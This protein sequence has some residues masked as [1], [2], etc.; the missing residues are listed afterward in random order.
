MT[1]PAPDPARPLAGVRVVEISSFVAVPLAG[2]TL[3]Q[4]GAEVLR[5]DPV[6]GAADY[7]RW[8]LTEAGDSIYWAGLNKGKRSLAVDM[9]SD[10]GQELVARLIA[11]SGVFITN[12]AGRQWHS[13]DA[14]R[15]IR[16]DL[17]HVEVSGRHDG[18]TGVDYTVNAAIGFPLVTGPPELTTPVNHV[19]PAW[20]VTCG[21]YAALSVVTALR[22][23]DATGHGQ[24]ISIPLENVALAT[25]GNLSLLTEAMI[26][27]TSR[28][29]IGNAVY[30]TYGQNFTS[31]DGISYMV[32][33]LTGRHFRDLTALT[34]TTE[35]VAVLADSL[36]ADFSDEGERYRHREALSGLFAEWFTSHTGVEVAAALSAT[37]VLWE[38][39]QTFGETA[40]APRVTDNPLFTELDQPRVGRYLA[41]GLP[42][43]INGAYPAAVPAPALG[44][45]TAAV[46]GD[47]LAMDRG[48]I[49]DLFGAGTVA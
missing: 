27:G 20:D 31:S 7:K 15:Q 5:V 47:W 4:L 41:A 18:G 35:A 37:S 22:H 11:D 29:R 40:A 10:T 23:R 43:S 49:D 48:R 1:E 25:A 21:I 33:A 44:D 9:R 24:Q 2:M 26:N 16:P 30:G 28:Q 42:L 6:G 46:L 34:G 45:D 38:R 17:I 8:P 32:V 13:Y 3:A 12:V 14:L 19:L 39:Y 36:G